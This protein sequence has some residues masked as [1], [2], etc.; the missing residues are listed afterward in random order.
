MRRVF[1]R[2][3]GFRCA[4][5]VRWSMTTPHRL[6]FVYAQLLWMAAS[7]L[8]LSA[9]GALSFDRFFGLS[10]VG[11]LLLMQLTTPKAV[12]PGWRSRLRVLA[13]L[14]VIGFG[15]VV[16]WRLFQALPPEVLP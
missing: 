15:I 14:G 7:V 16:S 4:I 3:P 8:G 13:T 12:D 1:E 2:H 6:R 10:L 9:V 5:D 11:L